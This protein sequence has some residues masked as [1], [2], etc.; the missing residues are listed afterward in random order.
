MIARWE[1]ASFLTHDNRA[2]LASYVCF[3][4]MSAMLGIY[5]IYSSTYW[6]QGQVPTGLYGL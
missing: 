1:K 5:I 4:A 6:P 3:A 2:G